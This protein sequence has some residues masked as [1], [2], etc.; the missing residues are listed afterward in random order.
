MPGASRRDPRTILIVSGGREAVPTIEEARRMG[1]RVVVADGAPDA[2]GFR[3]AD[4]ALL[5]STYDAEATV[6][7][8]R[9]YA[10]RNRIDGV[11]A[12]AADV[13]QTVA[14]VADA[15]DLPGISLETAFLA[16]DKLAMKDCF[17]AAGV[18]VPWYSA[19]SDA[20]ELSDL[21]ASDRGPL[22]VKP[23]DSRGARGVLRLLPGVDLDWAYATA[24]AA[25]PTGRVMVEAY[26]PGPQISTESAV[27]AGRTFTPG[28]ADRNYKLL[29]RFAPFVIEDGGELP[30]RLSER[31]RAEVD[32]VVG[33]AA[34]ALGVRY[35]TVKG[36]LVLGPDG[37]VV[38]ELAVRLSGGFFCSH[39]IPLATGVNFVGAAIRL[40]LGEAPSA[41]DLTPR[42]SKG[43]A[44]RYFFP[45][46]GIVEAIEGVDAVA[47]S[48]GIA[49]LEMRT[50]P[51]AQIVPV[52]SH[53]CRAGVVIAVADD[54]DTAVARAEAAAARVRII[55]RPALPP[56]DGRVLH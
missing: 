35:G 15:L 55:T 49:F 7:A 44:Q 10:S 46:P 8:A 29:D 51:G 33:D 38:I 40:A 27:V 6:E 1:L 17:R 19:V 24:A 53:V 37:P 50:A 2:P 42:W 12:A 4:A 20:E 16:S 3:L 26:V 18:P 48:E 54:R 30:S 36:D 25:S 41:A 32:A 47:A 52:T 5:A 43:V 11:I 21:V 39:H 23:V 28:C 56:A 34:A 31:D 9:A 13:P 45:Q 22:I 14:A